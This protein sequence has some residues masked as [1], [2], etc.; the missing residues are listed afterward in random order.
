MLQ[1]RG[2]HFI[3]WYCYCHFFSKTIE[4]DLKFDVEYKNV[5]KIDFRHSWKCQQRKVFKKWRTNIHIFRITLY[6]RYQITAV[7]GRTP[8]IGNKNLYTKILPWISKNY[9]YLS[10]FTKCFEIRIC[11]TVAADENYNFNNEAWD[12]I[13][14]D[15]NPFRQC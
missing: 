13:L 15:G 11:H 6:I 9:V 8:C 10:V 7:P 1:F 2:I 5:K 14:R 12:H 4:S 3:I